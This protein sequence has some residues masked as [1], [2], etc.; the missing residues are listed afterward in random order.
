MET[1]TWPNTNMVAQ[2][3]GIDLVV[4]PAQNLALMGLVIV[5]VLKASHDFS[6]QIRWFQHA[7]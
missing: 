4:F 5:S 6:S 2:T 3:V 1:A 7:A